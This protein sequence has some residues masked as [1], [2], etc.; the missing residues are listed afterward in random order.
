MGA[1]ACLIGI[2]NEDSG[3]IVCLN[4]THEV[5]LGGVHLLASYGRGRFWGSVSLIPVD[6]ENSRE[7]VRV[8][9]SEED[10]RGTV[11]W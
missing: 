6:E 4:V 7:S 5:R 3:R 11:L 8:I 10:S 9:V 1:C 2:G